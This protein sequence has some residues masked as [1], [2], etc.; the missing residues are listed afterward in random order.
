VPPDE[1][2]DESL[3]DDYF[4]D[5]ANE[6]QGRRT[7]EVPLTPPHQPLRSLCSADNGASPPRNGRRPSTRQSRPAGPARPGR[8]SPVAK[9]GPEPAPGMEAVAGGPTIEARGFRRTRRSGG[10]DRHDRVEARERVLD[11]IEVRPPRNAGSSDVASPRCH[12][13][14]RV[15]SREPR[16]LSPCDFRDRMT[17]GRVK[18]A[19][20]TTG[21]M[22][23]RPIHRGHR[24]ARRRGG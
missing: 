9:A 18:P 1:S 12:D 22:P 10:V 21:A 16:G 14:R 17:T 2:L 6:R 4:V 3:A 11:T 24:E 15:C 7:C 5:H 13:R 23:V 8:R 19:R 20:I